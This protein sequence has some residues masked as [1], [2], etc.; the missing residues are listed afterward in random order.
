M[1]R[2][3][4]PAMRHGDPWL[5]HH[6]LGSRPAIEAG[7]AQRPVELGISS[8]DLFHH[9]GLAE[10]EPPWVGDEHVGRM[11]A[12]DAPVRAGAAVPIGAGATTGSAGRSWSR[13][14]HSVYPT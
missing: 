9:L 11:A 6:E 3:A 7:V 2:A 12:V 14:R 10:N 5:V 4:A 1:W 13:H 8:V